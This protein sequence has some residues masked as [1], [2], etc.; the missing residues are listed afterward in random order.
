[1]TR[2][3]RDYGVGGRK[4]GVAGIREIGD[5]LPIEPQLRHTPGGRSNSYGQ[6]IIRKQ[7]CYGLRESIPVITN[8]DLIAIPEI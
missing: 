1:M 8:Q 6:A 2:F 5:S 3:L 7:A 4:A